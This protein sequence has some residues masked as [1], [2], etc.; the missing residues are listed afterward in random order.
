[1]PTPIYEVYV[2]ESLP[3]LGLFVR[4]NGALVTGLGSGHTFELKLASL[5]GEV[6]VTKTS[7]ITGQTGSSF[8]PLGTPNVVVQWATAAELDALTAEGSYRAQLKIT[9]TV[10]SRVRIYQWLVRA[11][12]AL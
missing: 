10:D 8:P 1:M 4:E 12:A 7:G 11:R 3:D 9:R 5:A 2:G 6:L